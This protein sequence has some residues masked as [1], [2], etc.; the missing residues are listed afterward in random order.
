M[1]KVLTLLEDLEKQVEEE[2]TAE[3]EAY[4]KLACFCK[5]GETGKSDDIGTN[6]ET[7]QTIAG[8]L[9]KLEADV[10]TLDASIKERTEKIGENGAALK[11]MEQIREKERAIFEAEFADAS[12]AVEALKQAITHLEDAQS[13]ALIS[14]KAE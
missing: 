11:E 5:D 4:E 9:L 12:K 13:S 1:E 6:E 2:G 8:D 3:A 10:A 14:N 7:L